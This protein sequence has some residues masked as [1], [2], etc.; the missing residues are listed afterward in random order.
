MAEPH[1]PKLSGVEKAAV[2]LMSMG[3]QAAAEVLKHMGPKEV[4]EIG[5]AMA[6]LHNVSKET[7][8]TTVGVVNSVARGTEFPATSLRRGWVISSVLA[9]RFS[10]LVGCRVATTRTLIRS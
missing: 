8:K 7:V 1:S 4:Q 10:R 3:E 5:I 9:A 6:S 2:L